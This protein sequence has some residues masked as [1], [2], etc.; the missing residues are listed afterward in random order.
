ME[1]AGPASSA[2]SLDP[3]D[4]PSL[5]AH[6]HRMLDDSLDYLEQIR[7]RPVRQPIP[8]QIRADFSESA[9]ARA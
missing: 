9:S 7:A 1:K 8:D 5:R 4:W 6:A 2:Q 3:A